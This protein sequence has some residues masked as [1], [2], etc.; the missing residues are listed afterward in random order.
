MVTA[1]VSADRKTLFLHFPSDNLWHFYL[2]KRLKRLFSYQNRET[3]QNTQFVSESIRYSSSIC[4]QC[5]L[6]SLFFSAAVA[7][8]NL[9]FTF[10]WSFRNTMK[11]H[12]WG[13][14]ACFC[15]AVMGGWWYLIFHKRPISALWIRFLRRCRC[16]V[17]I[18]L[19]ASSR[20]T[21]LIFNQFLSGVSSVEAFSCP[22]LCLCF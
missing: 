17:W 3:C 9:F 5:F 10:E 11:C 19:W 16:S 6:F 4:F 2:S 20:N 1:R 13:F 12:V 18:W 7:V 14:P 8:K 15:P 22:P 21:T